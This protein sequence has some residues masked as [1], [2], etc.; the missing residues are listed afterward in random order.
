MATLIAIVGMVFTLAKSFEAVC[1]GWSK[2]HP[3]KE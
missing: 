1:N 3:P 2:V